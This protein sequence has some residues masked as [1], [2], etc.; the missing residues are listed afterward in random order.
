[1][2]LN[3]IKSAF[4][5][6]FACLVLVPVAAQAQ[7]SSAKKAIK[8]VEA[9][10]APAAASVAAPIGEDVTKWMDD[11]SLLFAM[12]DY[13]NP[14]SLAALESLRRVAGLTIYSAADGLYIISS[15]ENPDMVSRLRGGYPELTLLTPK[16]A[17]LVHRLYRQNPELFK[18]ERLA[19]MR[20]E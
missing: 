11:G 2:L 1:M 14:Q 17:E 5:F 7:K 18:D 16:Q 4:I 12:I 13:K 9:A 19:K 10:P 3:S 15:K 8:K 6:V 20:G